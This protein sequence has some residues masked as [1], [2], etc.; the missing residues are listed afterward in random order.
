M[1]QILAQVLENLDEI[2]ERYDEAAQKLLEVARLDGHFDG[3]DANSLEWP[4]S[5]R[6]GES[7]DLA[8]LET[9]AELIHTIYVGTPPRRDRR[10][11]EAYEKYSQVLPTY[12]AANRIFLQLQR[13][14]LS[15]QVGTEADFRQLYHS[16]Y[17]EALGRENPVALDEAEAALIEFRV[18]RAPLSHAQAVAGKL[19]PGPDTDDLRWTHHYTYDI[20]DG[21]REDTLR[22]ILLDVAVRVV[23]ALAAGEHL[24]IRYNTFSNF[25][26]FGVSV[27]R[28]VSDI[29]LLLCRL[30]GKVGRRWLRKLESYLRLA[31]AMMLKF[32]QAHLED[33]AQIRPK[34]YWYGQEYSYLTRDLIDLIRGLIEGANKL[35]RRARG[36]DLDAVPPIAGLPILEGDAAGR[37]LEFAH[38]GLRG[39]VSRWQRAGRLASWVR[40]FRQRARRTVALQRG[41]PDDHN[42]RS[43]AWK[44]AVDWSRRTLE[45]FD[46]EVQIVID[47]GFAAVA[48]DMDLANTARRIVFFPT[49]QSLMDHP[50]MQHVLVSPELLEAM[51][52]REPVACCMLARSGL[53]DPCSIPIGSRRIS[54]LGVN[55][56]TADQL[57]KDVDGYVIIDRG[58]DSARPAAEFAKVLDDRPGVAYGAGTTSAF[59]LQ[60]LPM[61]HALFAYLPDDVVIIPIAMRGIHSLWPKCPKGNARINSGVVEVV[62]SPPMLGETTL[63]PRRRALRTQLEPATLFQAVH[64]ATLLDPEHQG[65]EDS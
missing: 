28:A 55:S 33:P 43:A 1:K 11:L 29:E 49:H 50:V 27:W 4:R 9:R 7:V 2:L 45:L 47:T 6:P 63:L 19:Q 24:A 41:K 58:D 10:L 17:L 32:L 37:F 38:V 34:E 65:R 54:L 16:V 46:I 22:E 36:I 21:P 59:D 39:E 26:W 44:N 64:I 12:H 40:I 18:A 42:R 15:R 48:A 60:V 14:F 35:R 61:Q 62:I 5:A 52:W 20:G 51:G 30:R 53:M 57:V 3:R 25:V 56:K 31:Q 23:D 13:Q 8:D